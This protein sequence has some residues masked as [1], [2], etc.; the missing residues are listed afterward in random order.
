VIAG[1]GSSAAGVIERFHGMP[2]VKPLARLRELE[3]LASEIAH[4]RRWVSAAGRDSA[5]FTVRAPGTVFVVTDQERRAA[6][7]ARARQLAFFVARN[8][9]LYHRQ[10]VR[11]GLADEA[12]AIR[13]AWETGG[14]DAAVA[15]LPPEL[16]RQFDFVGSVEECAERLEAQ[17]AGADLH[18]INVAERDPA[19]RRAILTRLAG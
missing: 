8:G 13:R 12:A 2:Y 16:A 10:F 7:E 17:A 5:A 19:I 1:L 6:R 3:R 9:E 11:H 18:Q 15:A 14:Q 4:L